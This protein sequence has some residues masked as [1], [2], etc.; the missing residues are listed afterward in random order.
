MRVVASLLVFI[1]SAVW[2][3]A[4]E[5]VATKLGYAADAKLLIISRR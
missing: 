3:Q 5:N 1:F 4:Q 2:A